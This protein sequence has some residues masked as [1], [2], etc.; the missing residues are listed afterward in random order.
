MAELAVVRRYARALIEAASQ[1]Q[2]VDAVEEDLRSIDQIFRAVPRLQ[3]ALQAP[4]V[5]DSRKRVLVDQAFGNRIGPLALRFL[6]LAINH[7]RE[8]ILPHIYAEYHRMANELRNLLPVE[9]TAAVPL[10]D[11]ERDAL[12]V[13]LAQRTGKRIELRMAIDPSLLGGLVLRMGDT[14]IDGSVRAKLE[15][16]RTQLLVGRTL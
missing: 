2:Q 16:L 5:P 7:D 15:Q 1:A 13:A 14:I 4:T 9:V 3:R 10:T 12:A 6:R 11:P 8:A